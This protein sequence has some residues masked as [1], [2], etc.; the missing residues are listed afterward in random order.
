MLGNTI[1]KSRFDLINNKFIYFLILLIVPSLVIG[2]AM[3]DIIITI[4]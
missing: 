1:N 2:P 4:L 3:P